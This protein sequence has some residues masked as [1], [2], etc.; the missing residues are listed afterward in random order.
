[1]AKLIY[2]MF[3]SLDGFVE[4]AGGGFGWAAPSEEVHAYANDLASPV[5]TYLFGR[6]MYE[7]MV[8]WETA[9]EL[10]GLGDIELAFA[11]GWRA[12]QKVVYSRSR[13]APRSERTRIEA[14]F[15]P[16]AV[17]RL[18]AEAEHDVAI[19]GPELAAQAVTAGLIDE[20][21]VILAPVLV[22]GGKRFF[23]PG[24]RAELRLVAERSF[25]DGFVALRFAAGR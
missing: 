12:A 8:F 9:H 20:Y 7:T 19:A 25:D 18:V 23:P 1:M 24:V 17:R 15:D 3:T 11:R 22:G 2:S 16:D 21:H 13:A 5:G 6:K 10:P 4:D 14:V